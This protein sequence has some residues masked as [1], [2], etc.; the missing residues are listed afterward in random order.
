MPVHVD[1]GDT[2]RQAFVVE[3]VH[4]LCIL[5]GA[6][7]VVAAPP[8]AEGVPR[9]QRG[10]AR[11]L[12]KI[13]ERGLM[14]GAVGEDVDVDV[15]LARGSEIRAVDSERTGIIEGR[16][17]QRAED[18]VV[19]LGGVEGAGGATEIERARK[20]ARERILEWLTVTPDRVVVAPALHL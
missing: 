8:V 7:A 1:D 10:A 19:E 17:A 14:C 6:V 20:Q 16:D 4:E 3:P 9:D 11:E 5:F 18:A 12:G 15:P 13:L 2:E